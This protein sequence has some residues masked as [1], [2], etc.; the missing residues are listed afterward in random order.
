MNFPHPHVQVNVPPQGTEAA[1]PD[2]GSGAAPAPQQAAKEQEQQE[3]PGSSDW[4][5]EPEFWESP[6][7]IC[8]ERCDAAADWSREEPEF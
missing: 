3:A 7:C 8:H 6:E 1:P 4:P 5:Q 2:A